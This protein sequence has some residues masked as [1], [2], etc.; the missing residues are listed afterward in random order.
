MDPRLTAIAWSLGQRNFS[1]LN[2]QLI[3]TQYLKPNYQKGKEEWM[4]LFVGTDT[5]LQSVVVIHNV[6]D[7]RNVFVC[8]EEL[9]LAATV[10]LVTY[11]VLFHREII[12][13]ALFAEGILGM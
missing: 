10:L 8:R 3:D 2:S 6:N 1:I 7:G 5:L 11:Y 13:I 4:W 12:D 9:Q